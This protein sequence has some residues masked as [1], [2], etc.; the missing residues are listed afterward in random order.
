MKFNKQECE[1][2]ETC[3][4]EK[5]YTK[6]VQHFKNEDYLYWK[7]F[8]RIERGKGGYSVGVS[9]YDF[10]KYPQFKEQ[11]PIS[12]QFQFMLGLNDDVDRMDLTISDDRFSVTDFEN[13][14]KKFYDFYKQNK[15]ENEIL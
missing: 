1:Q 13:F 14:C 12:I 9:F 3:L 7:S 5:G 2:F 4:K 6:Y 8:E 11:K 10:S 15:I